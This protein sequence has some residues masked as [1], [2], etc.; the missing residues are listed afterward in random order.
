MY[1]P[2]HLLLPSKKSNLLAK[3]T[4]GKPEAC[5]TAQLMVRMVTCPLIEQSVCCQSSAEATYCLVLGKACMF[6]DKQPKSPWM[7]PVL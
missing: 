2:L 4:P 5:E 1:F 7:L 6:Q 3:W